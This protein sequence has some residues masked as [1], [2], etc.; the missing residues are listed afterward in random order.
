MDPALAAHLRAAARLTPSWEAGV[1][2]G[3]LVTLHARVHETVDRTL[4]RG[5][6]LR[7][8]AVVTLERVW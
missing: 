7:P 3:T 6:Q 8:T 1:V 4:W 2:V 5:P